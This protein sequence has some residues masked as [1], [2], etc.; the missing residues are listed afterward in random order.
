MNE[1]VLVI[2]GGVAG[3]QASLDL[4]N[5]GFSVYMVEKEPSIGGRMSQFDKTFPTNDC[6]ICILAPKMIDCFNHPNITVYS[7]SELDGVEGSAGDFKVRVVR[8]PR[9]VDENKCTGC[10]ACLDVCRLKDRFLNE[11]EV[12]LG[13]RGA[14]YLP[15]LQAV[16]RVTT[17]DSEGCIFLTKGKCGK[18]PPCIDACEAEAIDFEQGESIVELNV[19]SIIVATGLDVYDPSDIEEYGF[20]KYENVLTGMQYERLINAAGPTHGHL[21]KPSDGELAKRLAFIHC[22][23]CRDLNRYAYCCAVCCMYATKDAMLA[24]EHDDEM[25]SY[26]FYSEL[27]AFGKGFNEYIERGKTDYE[28]NYIRSKPGKITEDPE[29]KN[30]TLWYEDTAT[31]ELKTLEVDMVVLA[32]ALTPRK[33]SK[34][35]AEILGVDLDR[36]GFFDVKDKLY[37]PTETKVPGIFVAG[38]CQSP[39]DIPDSIAQGSGAAAKATEIIASLKEGN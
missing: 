13:K 9:Y 19:S 2:G 18:S 21:E 34:K 24:R 22:V 10:C 38:Y 33:E 4:A 5:K 17:I 32:T 14:I 11:F 8:H 3:I 1:N 25:D 23:G 39:K 37:A 7:Y 6:S 36:Y 35:L 27:R 20:S 26:V 30:L 12:G 29:T 15:F 16:P 28:I 31:R